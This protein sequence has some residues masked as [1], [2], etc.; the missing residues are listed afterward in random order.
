MLCSRYLIAVVSQILGLAHSTAYYQAHPVTGA[1]V[2]FEYQRRSPQHE[3]G[4]IRPL[5]SVLCS[6]T[7]QPQVAGAHT[8]YFV[9]KRFTR[10]LHYW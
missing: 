6:I 9:G 4:T 7:H 8:N 2:A 5:V 1:L 3:G 10:W